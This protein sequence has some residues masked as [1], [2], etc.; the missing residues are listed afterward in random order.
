MQVPSQDL[1]PRAC[2]AVDTA[3]GEPIT[4]N[5]PGTSQ[6]ASPGICLPLRRSL[7]AHA[8]RDPTAS[9][10]LKAMHTRQQGPAQGA[11]AGSAGGPPLTGAAVGLEPPRRQSPISGFDI[12]APPPA[13]RL[14]S[15]RSNPLVLSC[16]NG[17]YHPYGLRD[18]LAGSCA[19]LLCPLTHAINGQQH[20]SSS[21][22]V[23]NS[24]CHGLV[25]GGALAPATGGPVSTTRYPPNSLRSSFWRCT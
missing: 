7:S 22:F 14:A 6:G 13:W 4:C 15:H 10:K 12:G 3:S 24:Q 16:S 11:G 9:Q 23:C 17:I 8:Q 20:S 18:R 2:P 21:C 19:G 1:F 5:L 25:Q